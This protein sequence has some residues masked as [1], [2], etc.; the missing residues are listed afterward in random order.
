MLFGEIEMKDKFVGW[1][2]CVEWISVLFEKK[3]I[4]RKDFEKMIFGV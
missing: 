2:K 4:G 1:L 3:F